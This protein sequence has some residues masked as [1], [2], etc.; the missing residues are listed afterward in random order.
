MTVADGEPAG[1]Q[2]PVREIPVKTKNLL[3]V[4]RG[5]RFGITLRTHQVPDTAFDH[6]VW[7][8]L[9][10]LLAL[11]GFYGVAP[12][13]GSSLIFIGGIITGFGIQRL[14]NH[15]VGRVR[16]PDQHE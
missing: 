15:R 6:V 12:A 11:T 16:E 9:G 13:G 8:I 5:G 1:D 2:S 10:G 3:V 4:R 7:A 14:I